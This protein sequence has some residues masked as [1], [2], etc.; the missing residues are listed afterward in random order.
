MARP[1]RITFHGAF[2]HITSRGNEQKKVF[3]SKRD[4]EKFLEY[5]ES[6]TER[7]AAVIHA[8]CLMDN[9]Y[10]L[11]LE[12]PSGNL[13]QIMRHIN[14]AYTTYFNTRRARSGHLFQGRYKAI[15]VEKDVYAKELSRYIHLNPVRADMVGTPEDYPWSSYR[16]YVGESGGPDWL[17][18]DFILAYFGKRTGTAQRG[19]RR[20]VRALLKRDYESP[21]KEVTG[22]LILGSVEFIDSIKDR[23]LR[24]E[25]DIRD[26]PALRQIFTGI[27]METVVKFTSTAFRDKPSRSR[28]AS[29]YLCRKHTGEKLNAIGR[30]FGISDSAVSQACKRFKTKMDDDK[31]L[32]KQIESIEKKIRLSKVET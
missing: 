29:I 20:F 17:Q 30:Q 11:L 21:L 19:Y 32:K 8:F 7:Y 3:K 15:L 18:R 14:G 6:A 13:P 22:S 26:L 31:E 27:S 2:Y 1:L 23:Y 10:H 16:Y 25:K 12:T 9:H 4:R 28:N 5:L 24:E